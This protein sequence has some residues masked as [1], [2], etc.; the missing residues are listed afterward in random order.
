[1]LQPTFRLSLSIG[2][3]QRYGLCL[4]TDENLH[5][6]REIWQIT[7]VKSSNIILPAHIS[8]DIVSLQGVGRS[9]SHMED[10]ALNPT[11]ADHK[12]KNLNYSKTSL[13]VK[14]IIC[15]LL[16]LVIGLT[17]AIIIISVT[18]NNSTKHSDNKCV[19]TS[20][21]TAMYT[22]S[23]DLYRDLS[24]AE[25]RKVR[26]YILKVVSLNVT[27]FESATVNSNYIFLIE[28]QNPIKDDA[29]AYLDHNGPKPTRVANVIL[30]KGA[31]SPPI[32]EEILV[33]FDKPMRHEP[34]TFLT[35]RTIPF[36]ARP[37]NKHKNAIQ[38]KI[39]DDFTTRAHEVLKELF[40]GY[41]I[42]NCTDR[43]LAYFAFTPMP[44]PNSNELVSIAWFVRNVPGR[45]IQPVGL[46]LLIRG[47]G[48]D[49]SK[50]KARVRY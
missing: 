13:L 45:V 2:D 33:Y 43:C 48:N 21:L 4:P 31:V 40:K 12:K 18:V 41:V 29:I 25:L 9:Q 27:P 42:K 16:L 32:V 8:P 3:V 38:E 44:T 28:L 17:V 34:N 23:Q 39:I 26:D 6:Y 24:K 5:F 14:V 15:F 46:E 35:N 30:F 11:M 1:M 20:S 47:K 49:E 37:T 50:W 10:T 36:H 22:K 19:T 7:R